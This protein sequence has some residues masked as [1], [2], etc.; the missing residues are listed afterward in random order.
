MREQTASGARGLGA[1]LRRPPVNKP[2]A[3]MLPLPALLRLRTANRCASALPA[4]VACI[5]CIHL[6][7]TH[8]SSIRQIVYANQ[9]ESITFVLI[10]SVG[11]TFESY[12]VYPHKQVR[13]T[14]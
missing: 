4:A 7:L 6:H 3:H 8:F 1:G 11:K 5:S 2:P 12:F 10:Q 13:S 9:F 14:L